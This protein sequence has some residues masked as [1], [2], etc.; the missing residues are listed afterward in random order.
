[1][2]DYQRGYSRLAAFQDC[3]PNFSVYRKHGWLHNRVLLH[4]QA[5]LQELEHEIQMVEEMQAE[6]GLLKGLRCDHIDKPRTKELLAEAKAKL[7]DYDDLL[8]RLQKKHAMKK[9]TRAMQHSVMKFAFA[10]LVNMDTHWICLTDDLVALADD[11]DGSWFFKKIMFW[12]ARLVPDLT[13]V[14]VQ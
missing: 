3:D 11:T 9:P 8:L 13:V 10:S 14:S 7:A 1:M 5:E 6:R 12:V 4:L 2:D